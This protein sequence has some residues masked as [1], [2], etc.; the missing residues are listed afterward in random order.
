MHDLSSFCLLCGLSSVCLVCR[1]SGLSD[2]SVLSIWCLGLCARADVLY[3]LSV[4]CDCL[5]VPCVRGYVSG[6]WD[7]VFCVGQVYTNRDNCSSPLWQ[8]THERRTYA[9]YLQSA[10]Y[11]SVPASTGP[12]GG[13]DASAVTSPGAY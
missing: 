7:G 13:I 6:V 4:V 8:K 11:R 9:A 1:L 10:G 3:C 5:S 2:V 12:L